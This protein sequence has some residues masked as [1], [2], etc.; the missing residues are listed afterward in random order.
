MG[1]TEELQTDF[2]VPGGNYV[3]VCFF[4]V[5]STFGCVSDFVEWCGPHESRGKGLCLWTRSKTRA[6]WGASQA[7][8]CPLGKREAIIN[9]WA[10]TRTDVR[11]EQHREQGAPP[12]P[13]PSPLPLAPGWRKGGVPWEG[14]CGL[15]WDQHKKEEPLRKF[16]AFQNP[17]NS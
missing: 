4:C 14:L 13:L 9:S 1:I 5:L 7:V 3:T 12:P 17:R 11:K 16:L 10:T 15:P 8:V 6:P 2:L